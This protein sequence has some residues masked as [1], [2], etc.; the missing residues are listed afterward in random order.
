M[1][2]A[3]PASGPT[4]S[5]INSSSHVHNTSTIHRFRVR[6]FT[7]PKQKIKNKNKS[8]KPDLPISASHH[9]KRLP[10]GRSL[11]RRTL[12]QRRLSRGRPTPPRWPDPT[13]LRTPQVHVHHISGRRAFLYLLLLGSSPVRPSACRRRPETYLRPRV[14]HAVAPL[15]GATVGDLA[16]GRDEPSRLSTPAP[17]PTLLPPCSARPPGWRARPLFLFLG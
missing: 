1:S 7:I 17:R 13:A 8:E 11:D 3:C 14:C 10:S 2:A 9:H 15:S 12:L 6:H 5:V 16:S 4:S